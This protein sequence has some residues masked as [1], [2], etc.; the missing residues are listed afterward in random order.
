MNQRERFRQAAERAHERAFVGPEYSA[1]LFNRSGGDYDPNSGLVTGDS[2]TKVTE[3]QVGYSAPN[4]EATVNV[5][6]TSLAFAG[7]LRFPQDRLDVSKLNFLGEDN[8]E[9][10]E[11]E[12]SDPEAGT[13]IYQCHSY[14]PEQ[15]SGMIQIDLVEA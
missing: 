13:Q 12:L 14:S 6:G 8:T 9:P 4:P 11:V 2:R 10:T 5:G 1:A 15:G 3:I 7:T